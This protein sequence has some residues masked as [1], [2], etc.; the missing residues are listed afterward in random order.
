MT[1]DSLA[2]GVAEHTN[3]DDERGKLQRPRV[4]L[5]FGGQFHLWSCAHLTH[6]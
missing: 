3:L 5:K 4:V 2:N 6:D 1:I